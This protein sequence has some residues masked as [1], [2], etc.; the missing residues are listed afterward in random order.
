VKN[1]YIVG[2]VPMYP[3]PCRYKMTPS[4]STP[5]GWKST[6]GTPPSSP[7]RSATSKRLTTGGITTRHRSSSTRSIERNSSTGSE[8]A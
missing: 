3:P 2:D 5:R 7:G 6:P 8:E 4:A 1:E